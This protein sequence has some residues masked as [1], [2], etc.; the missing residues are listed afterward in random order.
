MSRGGA[1]PHPSTHF[2]F[3]NIQTFWDPYVLC[4]PPSTQNH[5]HLYAWDSTSN[6]KYG[7]IVFFLF[8]QIQVK[9][10]DGRG[11]ERLGG[12]KKILGGEQFSQFPALGRGTKSLGLGGSK[13]G[14]KGENV[15]GR[16]RR[17]KFCLFEAAAKMGLGGNSS[18]YSRKSLSKTALAPILLSKGINSS[19]IVVW[20]KA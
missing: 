12:S 5:A 1:L 19:K 18:I 16:L 11:S 2:L 8:S 4:S 15:L 20:G 10:I 17:P 3:S 7:N 6:D 14:I 13:G 9:G